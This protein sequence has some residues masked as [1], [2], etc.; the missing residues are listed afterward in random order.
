MQITAMSIQQLSESLATGAL[1]AAEAA[2]VYLS[3][4]EQKDSAV[5]AYL[6]VTA[7]IAR[8]TAAGVD[9]DRAN[10]KALPPL[11]G[12]PVGIKDN[13]C[14][15]GVR[16]TC[17]SKMLENYIPPY[18]ATAVERL[19]AQRTVMLGKLN[20]DE[21]A[22]GSSTENSALGRTVNPL[23]AARVPG[24]SSGGSAAAVAAGLAPFA[25]GSDT[26]GSIRQPAAFCGVV[27][28]KPTY[29]A[30]SRY[31][32]VAFASSLDQIGPLTRTVGD[33]AQVLNAIC[34]HDPRDATS[35]NRP[36][37]GYADDLGKGVKGL[38]LALPEE[39]FGEG[40]APDVRQAVE[41][42]AMRLEREGAILRPVSMP[43]L[44]HALP[45]YYLLSSAEASSNLSRFDGVRYGHRAEGAETLSELYMRSRSEGFG[46]EVKR[47]ILL[48]TFALSAGY[49]DAYYKQALKVRTLVAR[50]MARVLST[51]DAILSP[52]APTVAY[53][54]GEKT[55]DPMT[56]YMGDICTVPA[57]IAGLPALSV[58]CG[59]GEGGM[60]V[61]L[62]LMGRAFDEKTLLRIAEAVEKGGA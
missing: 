49:V 41:G 1:T 19:S 40:I 35:V 14:T 62:Q 61:G 47:R 10:G 24:G 26:G 9:V 3:A 4:I 32:L 46:A 45:A 31:G 59:T 23:D 6:T 12:I 37:G 50:D 30:V 28:V 16:T 17:A 27:G 15:R 55:G 5:G 13:L 54:L 8:E 48:G 38:T 33:A 53:R 7:D 39:L 43:T 36:Y 57:N 34:A 20:M 11:A 58:P 29:G 42:A 21:F 56:M 51:C 44:R 22:M 25:L 52:V 60:P 18:S 2:E